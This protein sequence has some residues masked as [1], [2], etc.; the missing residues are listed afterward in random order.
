[1][2]LAHAGGDDFLSTLSAP[3]YS[4]PAAA[5]DPAAKQLA[6]HVRDFVGARYI[7]SGRQAARFF[8]VRADTTP[9]MLRSGFASQLQ[10]HGGKPLAFDG[11]ELARHDLNMLKLFERESLWREKQILGIAMSRTQAGQAE[12]ATVVYFA[13]EARD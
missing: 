10:K 5:D 11:P 6:G 8:K 2:M 4:F 12:D 3:A 13:L 1:M 9:D 7:I